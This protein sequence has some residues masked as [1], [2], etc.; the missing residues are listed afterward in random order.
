MVWMSSIALIKMTIHE[1]A[2]PMKNMY[3][4]TG[5]RNF[6]NKSISFEF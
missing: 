3:S 1:P 5:A 6:I 2:I 4:S